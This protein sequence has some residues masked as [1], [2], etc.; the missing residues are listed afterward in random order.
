MENAKSQI[1]KWRQNYKIFNA[2]PNI[3]IVNHPSQEPR[4]IN[5]HVSAVNPINWNT[6]KHHNRKFIK[7]DGLYLDSNNQLVKDTLYFWGEY[8]A[9][10]DAVIVNTTPP[11]AIHINLLP[12]MKLLPM[13][14]SNPQNTDPYVYGCF[15]NICCG[16]KKDQ[17]NNGDIIIF[18]KVNNSNIEFDTILVVDKCIDINMLSNTSQYYFASAHPRYG[19]KFPNYIEGQMYVPGKDYYSFVPCLPK[20]KV[21]SNIININ[22]IAAKQFTKPVVN[23][24]SL[25]K[26]GIPITLNGRKCAV[27]R[28]SN[29]LCK[30]LWQNIINSVHKVG[31]ELGVYIQPI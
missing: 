16:R 29:N 31:L 9:Y 2:M 13:P 3:Y 8:E 4:Y 11:Y 21:N 26:M 12:I 10:S 25:N 22:N 15:R 20:S 19:I 7:R 23:L 5:K 17:Y 18:G 28:V 1:I 30:L 24:Q 14:T 6:S 27:S